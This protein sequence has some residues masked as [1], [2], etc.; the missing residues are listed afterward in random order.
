MPDGLENEHSI[1]VFDETCDVVVVGYGDAGAVAAIEAHDRGARVL[2]IEKM[3]DPG[4]ISICA[5][6]GLRISNDPEAAFAYLK[7]TNGDTTPD[8]VLRVFADGIVGL[9][10]YV[11]D[12]A[13][14]NGAEIALVDREANYPFPG[15]RSFGFLE[16]RSIPGFDPAASY[17]H[18]R[19]S[20][21]KPIFKLLEDNIAQRGIEVR[22]ATVAERLIAGARKEVR[23][24]W[25]RERGVPKAIGARRGVVL[26]CG[27]FEAA[28]D[29][30]RQFWQLRPVLT[31][32]SL[33]NTGDGI[34]MAQ[35]LGAKLWHMWHFHG[36]YGF[37]HTS[38]DFPFAIRV[39]RLP[40]WTP[41]S[42]RPPVQ[43]SWI[44]VD[45]KGR[46]FVNEYEPYMQ[47]TGHR[48][49]DVVDPATQ[50][51]PYIPAYLI[52]DEDG[53]Q[54]YPLGHVVYND[55]SVEPYTWTRDNLGEV[56]LGI[57]KRAGSIPELAQI[58]GADADTLAATLA[59]W[60]EAVARNRDDA[61]GR[62]PGTM[63]PV[64]RPPFYVGE[65]WPLVSN[66]QGGPAHDARQRVLD[67]FD[68]PIPRLYEAGELGS[69]W[70]H[71]YLSGGNLSECFI[72]GRIA[73]REA[74]GNE[75]WDE[76]VSPQRAMPNTVIGSD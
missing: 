10:D 53:R 43:M 64:G 59:R 39:K 24:L 33:G 20:K 37:R 6:G 34:R 16:V 63:V 76:M 25:V 1:P 49:L 61:F 65:I 8:D 35:E 12:L 68:R 5:G 48:A 27:G 67:S 69:I 21:G 9:E 22:L 3:P 13:R 15:Y 38:P 18:A 30:Q 26:A 47:D 46:R 62:P 57:L 73:G 75:P 54:L 4:G 31:A 2:L 52:V 56:E 40:D 44:L 29:L 23:G 11:R 71:L 74:A 36:S 58:I 66:T 17:P 42:A 50:S 45:K 72:A 60:N 7:A 32:A 70:G 51:Y 41:G 55:G 14:V 28:P 19:A